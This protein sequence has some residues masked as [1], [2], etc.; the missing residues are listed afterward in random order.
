VGF[1]NLKFGSGAPRSVGLLADPGTPPVAPD[2]NDFAFFVNE[3]GAPLEEQGNGTTFVSATNPPPG[4]ATAIYRGSNAWSAE[5]SI[6]DSDLGG[7][8]H[9]ASLMLAHGPVKWPPAAATNQPLTWAPVFLGANLPPGSNLPPVANAGSGFTVNPTNNLTLS[10]D[11]SASYDPDGDPL[12][13]VWNQTGGPAVAMTGTNTATPAVTIAPVTTGT[14]LTFQLVV[15]DGST[16]SAP[17]HVQITV[18]PPLAKPAVSGPAASAALR[19]DGTLEL[20]L[21]GTPG[22]PYQIQA[23][24][25][26]VNWVN[27]SAVYADYAGRIDF[28]ETGDHTNYPARFYRG[29][30]Q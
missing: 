10:L 20:Q 16:N 25:N 27:L 15:G 1:Y 22:Q 19:S 9:L 14:N 2:T 3:N 21:V 7:W 29:A 23:S 18:L 5:L 8:G 13:Y 28:E 17:S 12:T 26:L 4:F 6:P 11:G 24:S 30:A